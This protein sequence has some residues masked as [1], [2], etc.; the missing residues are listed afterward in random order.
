VLGCGTVAV[1]VGAGTELGVV[2]A[3]VVDVVV[4]GW[5]VAA[6]ASGAPGAATGV[7]IAW[8]LEPSLD[9]GGGAGV[10]AARA[11]PAKGPPMPAAVRP[12]PATAES[13]ARHA[14][15][16]ALTVDIR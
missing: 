2:A 15:R 1:V 14:H 8:V 4:V 7:V 5:G 3:G 12:P 16:R 6:P 9:T 10:P 13:M 11:A